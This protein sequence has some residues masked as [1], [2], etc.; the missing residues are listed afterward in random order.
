M[1]DIKLDHASVIYGSKK[2]LDDVSITFEKGHVYCILG[3]NGCGKS[4]LVKEIINQNKKVNE[5]AYVAQE[6]AGNIALTTYEY[7][8]LGRYDKSKFFGGLTKRDKELIDASISKMGISDLNDHI[9]D[10]L[11]GGEKQRAMIARALAQD[12]NWVIM[13]EPT[14]SLDAKH[15]KLMTEIISELKNNNK[16]VILVIHDLN[17]AYMVADKFVLM[18]NGKIINV[19]DELSESLLS[20]TYD[21]LFDEVDIGGRKHFILKC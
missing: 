4:T 1:M 10:T 5:I 20:D 8:S 15:V 13:D 18:K 2:A 21:T 7:I 16:S 11:S 19:V 14:S 12:S 6:S 3:A 9:I 17:A